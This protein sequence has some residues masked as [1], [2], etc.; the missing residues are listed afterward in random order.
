M[1][2]N[3]KNF[4]EKTKREVEKIIEKYLPRKVNEKWLNFVFGKLEYKISKNAI[5]KAILNPIWD[6]LDRGGKRW[7]PA[8][9]LL[10]AKSLGAD[11]KKIK[12]FS[13]IPELAHNGSL[14]VDDIEDQGELRRG[15]PCLHK[16]FGTDIAL[17]AGNFL[18]FLPILIIKKKE[19]EIEGKL[20][21]KILKVYFE[22][23][24][25]LH[26]GQ[27]TDIFWHKGFQKEISE[28]EYFQMTA[29]KTG[30]MARLAARM[31]TIL[32]KREELEKIFGQFAQ[33]IGIAFQIQDDILDICLKG[34]ER[35][36]FGKSYGNDIKEG[37][38]SLM[39][40]YVLKKATRKDKKRLLEILEKHTEDE[41]EIREAIS[42]L[43]K[44][45][46]IDYAK[47]K[48]KNLVKK[49]WQKVEKFLPQTREKK[50][51]YSFAKFLIERKI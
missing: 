5:Q 12:D 33:S 41:K 25:N 30:C 23:M 27:G 29:F 36:K 1:E 51:L 17:N 26:F 49:A 7:R 46:S 8:L 48:A 14:I 39:V 16:I 34:K 4:F 47:N 20:T 13:V 43:E 2:K 40:I 10:I 50:L 19:K 31:A 18:Y 3:L 9:F 15:K 6:F 21:Q 22:E 45:K 38:K 32:A 28:K 35:E 37:K 42:I 44:Y 24:L 11:I